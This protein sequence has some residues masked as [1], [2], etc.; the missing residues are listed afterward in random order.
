MQRD[1]AKVVELFLKCSNKV[2]RPQIPDSGVKRYQTET[3]MDVTI[4]HILSNSKNICYFISDITLKSRP[5]LISC[6]DFIGESVFQWSLQICRLLHEIA[7]P[8]RAFL[9]LM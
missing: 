5:A 1:P 2:N 7:R 9:R 8:W 6:L 4:L 3:S